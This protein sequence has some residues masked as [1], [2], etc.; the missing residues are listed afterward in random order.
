MESNVAYVELSGASSTATLGLYAGMKPPELQVLVQTALDHPDDLCAGFHVPSDASTS[1]L[2][3]RRR[4]PRAIPRLVPLSVACHAPELLQGHVEAL[5]TPSR[6]APT[7]RDAPNDVIRTYTDTERLE[8]LLLAL[9]KELKLRSFEFILLR[10]LCEQRQ[11]HVLDVMKG[12]TSVDEKKQF[13]LEMLRPATARERKRSAMEPQRIQS[14]HD[15]LVA[16]KVASIGKKHFGL[17]NQQHVLAYADKARQSRKSNWRFADTME[18]LLMAGQLLDDRTLPETAGVHLVKLVLDEHNVLGRALESYQTGESSVI[19]LETIAKHLALLECETLPPT[20]KKK[21]KEKSPRKSKVGGG[22]PTKKSTRTPASRNVALSATSVLQSLKAQ[23]MVT[24]LEMEI[25]MALV[26]QEDTQVLKILRAFEQEEE[27]DEQA[28]RNA[29]VSVVEKITMD[30]EDDEKTA[31]AAAA[32]AHGV[33]DAMREEHQGVQNESSGWQRHLSYLLDA[34]HAQEQLTVTEVS[35][36]RQMVLQRHNL[37]ES[38]YEVFAGEGD[39]S[40]LLDTLQR[41]AKLQ[42]QI[43]HCQTKKDRT[44]ASCNGLS[45]ENVVREMQRRGMIEATDAAGLLMLFYGGNEALQ[46]ANEAYEADGDVNELEE[47]LLLVVKHARFGQPDDEKKPVNEVQAVCRLLAVLG[48][49]GRLALWQIQLLISLVKCA[50]PRLLAAVDVYDEDEN[51]DELVD[52]LEVLVELVAWERHHPSMLTDWITPLVRS[53]KVGRKGAERLVQLV[54]ARDD[55][56]VAALVVFLSDHNKDE[57]MDTLGR[58]AC[59][60]DRNVSEARKQKVSEGYAAVVLD[61]W[62]AKLAISEHERTQI[63][64]LMRRREPRMLAAMD[65]LVATHD[66]EDFV[67]TARR[68]VARVNVKEEDQGLNEE[69]LTGEDKKGE[70]GMES[71]EGESKEV[72]HAE[73]EQHAT[74]MVQDGND[75]KRDEQGKQED[76]TE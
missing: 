20:A 62:K 65:V 13:L 61:Q 64:T 37:L 59:L 42:Q 52:T 63:E 71:G 43:Q 70:M 26:E 12:D 2:S 15:E 50:D 76:T 16:K 48:R 35:T 32:F 25:L 31:A 27:R 60:E 55:R 39:A 56:I 5:F 18:L 51:L 41:V 66:A 53:G 73:K 45:L 72:V 57:F 40:E 34:W 17:R 3:R 47:T 49:T 22:S 23:N 24:R 29:L 28:L 10:Y 74:T 9:Q 75:T 19:D 36:L 30:F 33:D 69:A 7:R 38:A 11:T 67:D 21:R 14:L 1:R 8:T 44:G 54:H 68:I 4:P 6:S 46:A 58:L